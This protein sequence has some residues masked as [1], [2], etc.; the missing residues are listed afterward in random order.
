MEGEEEEEL[1]RNCLAETAAVAE[2]AAAAALQADAAVATTAHGDAVGT[3]A[4]D[5]CLSEGR[6]S[7]RF[8]VVKCFAIRNHTHTHKDLIND[9]DDG[10]DGGRDGAE[11]DDD[12]AT[13][14]PVVL[15]VAFVGRQ[16]RT[17]AASSSS[18]SSV[19]AR[20]LPP[21]PP[22]DQHRQTDRQTARREKMI[23]NDKREDTC[24]IGNDK[25]LVM[26]DGD[27]ER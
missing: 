17:G 19:L 13:D 27:R 14:R 22:Y 24:T 10:D 20:F 7:R 1:I 18:S 5:S 15:C 12:R 25:R 4:R 11:R 23:R 9:D 2:A 16:H 6:K 26:E 8:F 21:P 3:P